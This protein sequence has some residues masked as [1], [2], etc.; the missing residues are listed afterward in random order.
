MTLSS[1][2]WPKWIG[3]ERSRYARCERMVGDGISDKEN[4]NA[5]RHPIVGWR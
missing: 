4:R 2:F 1:L 3:N 5:A